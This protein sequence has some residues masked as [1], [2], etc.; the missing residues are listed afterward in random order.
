M[1]RQ[2][3]DLK[4]YHRLQVESPKGIELVIDV[5][6]LT[7]DAVNLRVA[8]SFGSRIV[9]LCEETYVRFGTVSFHNYGN[10]GRGTRT[11]VCLEMCN[12]WRYS[13]R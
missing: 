4:Q 2:Y 12:D 1:K 9:T 11:H 7:S 5:L 8:N 13:L 6:R 3:V 10:R